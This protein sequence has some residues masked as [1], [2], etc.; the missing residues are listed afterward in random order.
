MA[1]NGDS[2]LLQSDLVLLPDTGGDFLQRAE[3]Y[4][5]G[6]MHS[7][8][9]FG[10]GGGSQRELCRHGVHLLHRRASTRNVHM[11]A[12]SID[13]N[14]SLQSTFGMQA[15]R[16]RQDCVS[17]EDTSSA[18]SLASARKMVTRPVHFNGFDEASCQKQPKKSIEPT[19]HANNQVDVTCYTDY[20]AVVEHGTPRS[21]RDKEKSLDLNVTPGESS[22]SL[23]SDK[24]NE[25]QVLE[26][27]QME[28]QSCQEIVPDVAW[29]TRNRNCT[30]P[31]FRERTDAKRSALQ[32]AIMKFADRTTDYLIDPAIGTEFDDRQEAY[33]YYNLYSWEI[34][35]GIRFG[36]TRYSTD[37]KNRKL[38]G[39]ERYILGQEFN[40]SYALKKRILQGKPGKHVKYNSTLTDC[41]AFLRLGRTSY[42]GWVVVAHNPN[43]NHHLSE[44]YC[45]K[46]QWPSH[47]HLDR[48]TKDLVRMLRENNVGIT[49]LYSIL[50]NFFGSMENVPTTKRSLKNLCQKIN[51]E[52]AVDDINKTL[53]LFREL[54]KSDPGFMYSVNA[55]SE[56]RIKTLIWKNSRSCMRHIL[57]VLVT[58]GATKIPDKLVMKRWTKKARLHLP[59]HLS[60]YAKEN[61]S[62]KALPYRHTSLMIKVLKLVEM[63]DNNVESHRMAMEIID[64]GIESLKEVSKEKDGMGLADRNQ[65]EC[66]EVD[67]DDGL[68]DQFPQRV[69]KRRQEKGRQTNKRDKSAYENGSK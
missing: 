51:R 3:G 65:D 14:E 8:P 56:G 50:G 47:Y 39:S 67:D 21:N 55:D 13:L 62:L 5:V 17:A 12:F 16:K 64:A 6:A 52:Q 41:Q 23:S 10:G 15:K 46:K 26:V 18:C 53:H 24:S 63:G 44:S 49:K 20:V 9:P 36:K 4:R 59:G 60:E 2:P 30:G 61:P 29:K 37:R 42:N 32:R 19:V 11:K 48:Y 54:R 38:P 45:E 25:T 34:G 33:D 7:I 66:E 57:R 1:G 28:V 58:T 68:L 27:N 22:L 43:H 40:C 31:N 35:F 69:P